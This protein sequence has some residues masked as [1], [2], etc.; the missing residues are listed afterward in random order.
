MAK[1]E[2][3][4]HHVCGECVTPF[5][6]MRLF[7]ADEAI[8]G[9][10][11]LTS[12]GIADGEDSCRDSG[13]NSLCSEIFREWGATG[14]VSYPMRPRGT[15]FQNLVWSA[16]AAVARGTMVSYSSLA[17]SL[18]SAGDARHLSR[19]VGNALG[20]NPIALFIPCHRVI[21]ASGAIGGY[22]WGVERKRQI[23]AYE[24]ND[25]D[26]LFDIN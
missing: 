21:C 8:V 3:I 26:A 9:A 20:A 24:R 5:G 17:Q 18:S 1:F 12:E 19:A 6:P 10:S 16:V 13:L 15:H 14:T 4:S 2:L 7:F 23:L 11:F 25:L 22:R